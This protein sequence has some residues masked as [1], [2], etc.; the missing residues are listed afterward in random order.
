MFESLCGAPPFADRQGM[1]VLWAH[2]QDPPPNPSERRPEL[3]PQV[4]SV[5]L[6][7]LDKD[8]TGRPQSAGDF[9]QQ[10]KAAAA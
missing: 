1:R 3:P 4:S 10:L 8:P 9:A 2:L 5:I 7:A 6:L